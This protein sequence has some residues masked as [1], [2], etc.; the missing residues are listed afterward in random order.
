MAFSEDATREVQGIIETT[1][2]A[3]VKR[4]LNSIRA[5]KSRELSKIDGSVEFL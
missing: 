5:D 4:G 1:R 2:C 3:T